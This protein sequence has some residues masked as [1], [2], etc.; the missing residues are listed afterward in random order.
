MSLRFLKVASLVAIGLLSSAP[1]VAEG[2][3]QFFPPKNLEAGLGFLYFDSDGLGKQSVYAVPV[4]SQELV[5]AVKELKDAV[6][7]TSGTI[8]C[9]SSSISSQDINGSIAQTKL[10]TRCV[11]ITTG[12]VCD[13]GI[14]NMYGRPDW[15]CTFPFSTAPQ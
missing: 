1:A 6:Q 13:W 3:I 12:A 11:N 5:A 7:K 15:K 14:E 10:L 2:G 4:Q 8:Q 9:S